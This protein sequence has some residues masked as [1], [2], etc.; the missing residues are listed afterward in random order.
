MWQPWRA[1]SEL[2][3]D[4]GPWWAMGQIL[5]WTFSL[6]MRPGVW[7][8]WH[9]SIF[10]RSRW[11]VI[12]VHLYGSVCPALQNWPVRPGWGP[13][14]L[15]WLVQGW[16]EPLKGWPWLE[17][18]GAL[19]F[20]LA[21]GDPSLVSQGPSEPVPYWEMEGAGPSAL[22]HPSSSL[23]PSPPASWQDRTQWDVVGE[24]QKQQSTSEV[25]LQVVS[26]LTSTKDP[27]IWEVLGKIEL[28]SWFTCLFGKLRKMEKKN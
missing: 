23:T 1:Q 24:T 9:S 10:Q 4:E 17:G 6:Q 13:D 21:S 15:C 18:T 22:G 11:K 2:V 14:C 7:Y 8:V 12:F 25:I 26:F 28:F 20:G 5:P 27:N 19:W 3:Q 16:A